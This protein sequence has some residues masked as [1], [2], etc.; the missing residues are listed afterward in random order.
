LKIPEQI[1][2]FPKEFT[3]RE[4]LARAQLDI[5]CVRYRDQY[6]PFKC[7]FLTYLAFS[8]RG[9]DFESYFDDLL[10]R[11]RVHIH[12]WEF[13][14]KFVKNFLPFYRKYKD[15]NSRIDI[16]CTPVQVVLQIERNKTTYF[17]PYSTRLEW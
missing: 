1:I 6:I 11:G 8:K 7:L 10:A 3:G 14:E 4:L 16:I 15:K 9:R 17:I 13:F 5:D 12:H 2:L